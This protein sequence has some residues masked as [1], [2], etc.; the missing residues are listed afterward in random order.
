M[1]RIHWS[2]IWL[3]AQ[4]LVTSHYTWGSVTTL[5]DFGGVLGQLLDTFFRDLT[6]PWSWLLACVW[7]RPSTKYLGSFNS[8]GVPGSRWLVCMMFFMVSNPK[9]SYCGCQFLMYRIEGGGFEE[10][11]LGW[12]RLKFIEIVLRENHKNIQLALHNFLLPIIVD[13]IILVM[14]LHVVNCIK[15]ECIR[16]SRVEHAW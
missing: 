10:G 6:I 7:S 11:T 15:F 16:R 12:W 5:H 9:R 3:R 1:Y 14:I 8:C 4:S 13:I 2:G